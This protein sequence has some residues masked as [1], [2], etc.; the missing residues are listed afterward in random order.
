MHVYM[1]VIFAENATVFFN[2]EK[3]QF[4][5]TETNKMTCNGTID[6][7]KFTQ[8]SI[9]KLNVSVIASRQ[10]A[11]QITAN[12]SN[13]YHYGVY[14]CIVD[15]TGMEFT[16]TLFLRNKGRSYCIAM[17]LYGNNV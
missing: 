3:L 10:N 1:S 16:K 17:G 2:A 12:G 8:I 11:I 9:T 6:F 7:P 5:S 14:F 4:Y 13:N 15:A